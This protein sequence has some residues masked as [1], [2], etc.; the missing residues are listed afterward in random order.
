MASLSGHKLKG[1]VMAGSTHFEYVGVDGC[2]AGWFS[3]GFSDDGR[4]ECRVF[5]QFG[6]LV[7]HDA[8]ARL[9]LVD[10]PI[11]LPEGPGGRACD[12]MARSLLKH[13]HRKSSVFPVP[14]RQAAHQARKEPG[15]RNAA[16]IVEHETA[17]KCLNAQT[18]NISP[19][20]AEVDTVMRNLNLE[21]PPSIREVHPELCFWAM[22]DRSAMDSSKKTELGRNERLQVLKNAEPRA[23]EIYEDACRMYLRKEVA[24]DDVLDALVAAVTARSGH[25]RLQTV[26]KCPQSDPK[27]LPMEMVY[28]LPD[29]AEKSRQQKQS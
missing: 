17:G 14:T 16:A 18:F 11:G 2:R 13:S 7:A 24:R 28:W 26:P 9:I 12:P 21:D 6:E 19:K 8:A 4:Y 10:I 20:I 22:N 25:G 1:S 15:N 5:P 3:V 29:Y 27:G 23:D